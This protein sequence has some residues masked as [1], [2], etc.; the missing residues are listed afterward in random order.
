MLRWDGGSYS[1]GNEHSSTSRRKVGMILRTKALHVFVGSC[2]LI[3]ITPI[4]INT[5][6]VCSIHA[7]NEHTISMIV[8]R[9]KLEG[10]TVWLFHYLI[11]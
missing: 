7:L 10:I 9:I 8:H 3:K 2:S 11:I 6:F 4:S 5:V 1:R